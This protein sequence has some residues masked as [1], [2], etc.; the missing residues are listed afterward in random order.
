MQRLQLAALIGLVSLACCT[1]RVAVAKPHPA[2][3]LARWQHR[4]GADGTIPERAFTDMK[5]QRDAVLAA[6]ADGAAAAPPLRNWQWMGPGNIG[7]RIRGIAVHP[8]NPSIM[9]VGAVAGGIWKTTDAGGRWDPK[10]DFLPVLPIGCLVLEPGNPNRLYAGT[11]EG[12]FDSAA[13]SSNLAAPRGAGVFVSS[14]GGDTWSQLPSTSGPDWYFVNRI[15]FDPNDVRVMLAATAS[16]IF[17]SADAGASWTKTS[18]LNAMDV[19]FHP[20]D[21][22]RAV[23]GTGTGQA[24]YSSNGGQSWSAATGTGGAVRIE[25]AYAR[26]QPTMVFAAV[27]R[28]SG[29]IAVYRS[30][31]GGQTYAQQST[32]SVSTYSRYN[33]L[34]WVDPTDPLLIVVGGIDLYRSVDGGRT[35]N[36]ISSNIHPDHHVLVEHPNYN[37]TSNRTVFEGNDGGIYRAADIRT[38]SWTEL[39]NNLGITQFYGAAINAQSGRIVAGAQDNGTLRYRGSTE[40]WVSWI[41][42]DG[43]FCAADWT[44]P[45]YFYGETQYLG[46]YRSSNGGQSGS[47]ISGGIGESSPNFV[48]PFLLD[49]N[50]PRRMLAGGARLWRTNNV[51]AGA[52]SWSTIKASST[53][54]GRWPRGGSP[55]HFAVDPPY[56]ISAI[57]VA[58]GNPN[59]IWVGHNSGQLY[60]TTDGTASSPS[61]ARVD[62]GTPLPDRFISRIAI[63]R[64]NHARVWVTL[65]GYNAD[66]VWRTGDGGATWSPVAG[67]GAAALPPAPATS[68]A[69][70]RTL[71]GW[72]YVGTDVGVFWTADD[73]ATWATATA[74]P[75]PAPVDEVVWKTDL[76]LMVVTHG[77]GV[78]LADTLDRAA[79]RTVG[80][81]CGVSGSPALS[82]AP[83]VLGA[84]QD[85]LLAAASA[86]APVSLLLAAGP[87]LP[88]SLGTCTLQVAPASLVLPAGATDPAGTW[89]FAVAIPADPSLAGAVVTAQVFIQAAG[90][91]ALGLGELSNGVEMTPGL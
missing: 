5:A 1:A 56:N 18:A 77:R 89:R 2:G 20:S 52:V 24:L 41:G 62:T 72:A 81:G 32:N 11:G 75:G 67:S 48:A 35:L 12:F 22:S 85:Y 87:A 34:L 66:N 53:A 90:G 21:S 14:D 3:V 76:E 54:T 31:D 74:G 61:W 82:V 27:S 84:A 79:A 16:G 64:A 15:A 19:D 78:Y 30:T 13:G 6:A 8:A 46:I 39:N 42:G 49:P 83:P 63:D 9:W 17:R 88:T 4:A 55:S 51:K 28:G 38:G 25:T 91:P 73:G 44:D 69:L 37:G 65:Q 36:S 26:S 7:G 29:S 70:H 71:A 10:N 40:S 47:P 68:I 45:N 60:K 23:A 59:L 50:D 58:E 80:T 86:N 43:A 33:N 57:A